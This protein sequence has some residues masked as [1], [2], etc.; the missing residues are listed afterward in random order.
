MHRDHSSLSFSL[1]S[2]PEHCK[3]PAEAAG[4]GGDIRRFKEALACG[5]A[6]RFGGL[7]IKHRAMPECCCGLILGRKQ[8]KEEKSLTEAPVTLPPL[9]ISVCCIF[10]SEP[11]NELQ[12]QLHLNCS[13]AKASH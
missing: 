1:A 8:D 6:Y 5:T 13:E 12:A 2:D 9:L 11:V 10:Q 4:Q 7:K 3:V